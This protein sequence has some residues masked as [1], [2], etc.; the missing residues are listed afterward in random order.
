M[1]GPRDGRATV[2]GAEVAAFGLAAAAVVA[3]PV[4]AV[5]LL[6]YGAL[7]GAQAAA[8]GID[9]ALKE[10]ER[11]RG[12]MRAEIDWQERPVL[13]LI[14]NGETRWQS[15]KQNLDSLWQK[16]EKELTKLR[17]TGGTPQTQNEA[18]AT[19]RSAEELRNKAVAL[20]AQFQTAQ[21]QAKNKF[22]EARSNSGS[23]QRKVRGIISD[24]KVAGD[25]AVGAVNQAAEQARLAAMRYEETLLIIQKKGAEERKTELQRQNAQS[26]ITAA[27][28]E[29][30]AENIAVISE[31]LGGASEKMLNEYIGKAEAELSAKQ[32]EKATLSA[33]ESVAVYRKLYSEAQKLKQQF[34][35]REIIADALVA[36]LTDMQYDKPDVNYEPIA[37]TDNPMLGNLTI[38]AKS[39]GE[40]GDMWLA[41]DLDGNVKMNHDYPE[42]NEGDCHRTL[43]DLQSHVSDVIDLRIAKMPQPP[44]PGGG[45]RQQQ[46]KVQ[47]QVRQ[48]LR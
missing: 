39:R 47:E 29:M 2:G 46:I 40:V 15:E 33:Q 8:R 21:Q 37:G 1:S 34:V 16:A 13:S 27:K 28:N 35:N 41:V 4:V 5:G 30:P 11:H 12:N 19:F 26:C 23:S 25:Q 20:S 24:G 7:K 17:T 6:G 9:N 3:F 18:E 38:F 22:A 36:A 48:R 32:Y 10:R 43:T 45:A 31:W 14:A 44:Q 42:E